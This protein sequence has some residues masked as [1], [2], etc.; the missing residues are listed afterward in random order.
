[1]LFLRIAVLSNFGTTIAKLPSGSAVQ[2]GQSLSWK[3]SASIYCV[4][5]MRLRSTSKTCVFI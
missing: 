2:T 1:M 5:R 4:I 3:G